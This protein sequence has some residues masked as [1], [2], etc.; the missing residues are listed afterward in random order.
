MI[1]LSNG[2]S[3]EYVTASGALGYDGNGWPWEW[4]LRW[5]GLIDPSFF[6]NVMKTVTLPPRKGNLRWWKPWDCIRLM[7]HGAVNAVG[8]T[9]PGPDWL[10]EKIGPKVNSKKIPLVGELQEM[11]EIPVIALSIWDFGDIAKLRAKGFKAFS[12]GS[13]FL[14]Y[15]WRPTLC[16]RREQKE[17]AQEKGEA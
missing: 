11:T 7:P 9:N 1:T 14:R 2:F 5:L 15:P 16:V 12:F 8:L 17:K 3:F 6:L 10:A 4:P 13:V